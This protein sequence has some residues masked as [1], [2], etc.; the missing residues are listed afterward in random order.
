MVSTK[1]RRHQ[2]GDNDCALDSQLESGVPS[3]SHTFSSEFCSDEEPLIQ[4]S[5]E[6]SPL[7]RP[8]PLTDFVNDRDRVLERKSRGT[9]RR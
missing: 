1:R 7:G 3:D 4:L 8:M 5:D 9:L 6:L 2:S